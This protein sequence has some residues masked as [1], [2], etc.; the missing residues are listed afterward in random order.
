MR[1]FATF[2]AETLVDSSSAL[3]GG[4]IDRERDDGVTECD[5]VVQGHVR[6]LRNNVSLQN[7][8]VVN[9]RTTRTVVSAAEGDCYGVDGPSRVVET[10]SCEPSPS[11]MTTSLN[12]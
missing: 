12:A 4:K 3:A 1:L 6:T 7:F 8:G 5:E 10:A 11:D 2:S 9:K